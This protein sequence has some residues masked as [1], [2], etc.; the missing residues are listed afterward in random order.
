MKKLLIFHSAL[1]PYRVD[2][3]NA[4]A[5]NF[6]CR[7]IF[8]SRNNR[9]QSFNQDALLS[10]CRFHY[11]FMD[12]KLVIKG[13]DLNLGYL[14]YLWKYKPDIV[15]GGEYGLSTLMPCIYKLLWKRKFALYTICDD[16]LKIAKEC[17]GIRKYLRNFLVKHL[18]GIILISKEVEKWYL[19]YFRISFKTIVFPIINNEQR[20]TLRLEN[21]LPIS[22]DLQMKFGLVDKKV[23][24]FVGRLTE[25]KNLIFLLSA[26]SRVKDDDARL[27]LVGDGE[28]REQLNAC[29]NKLRIQKNVLFVGRFEGDELYAWYNLANFLVL[30]SKYEP[31]GAVTAEA[32]QAGCPVLCSCDAGSATLIQTGMNGHIFHPNDEDSFVELLKKCILE[33]SP[34]NLK[35][36]RIR[37]SLLPFTFNECVKNMVNKL[38]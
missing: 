30:P 32:L 6:D 8:L 31:F 18:N 36:G 13:R 3:F 11:G 10:Q 33:S 16:S 15:I 24:L 38:I 26:F 23:I 28:L 2:F 27:V 1:A 29:V 4:L 9:N 37:K 25:V 19:D 35:E 5:D 12:K 7:V 14:Y 17:G 22:V 20:Y 21:V 34:L